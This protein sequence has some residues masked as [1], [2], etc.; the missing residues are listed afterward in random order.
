MPQVGAGEELAHGISQGRQNGPMAEH[1]AKIHLKGVTL[2][3]PSAEIDGRTV[4][5]T[6]QWLKTATVRD[7]ELVQGETIANPESFVAQLKKTRL[8]VDLFTFAQ[9]LPDTTPRYRYYTEWENAAALPITTFSEWWKERTEYSIRKGVNR[10]KKLGLVVK[11]AEFSDELVEGIRR[12][13]SENPVRQG[14]AFWHHGKGFQ[15]LKDE[16]AT[17]LDRSVFIGAY[18]RDEL[19][20]SM[21]ITYVGSTA[22]IMQI[23]STSKH[24]DKRPNNALIA[25][26]VEVCELEGKSHLIYGDF[27]YYDPNSMLTEFKRR[28]GFEPVPAPRYYIPLTFK[29]KVALQLGLH[30]GLAARIPKAVYGKLL[31]IRSAWYAQRLKATE[32][33]L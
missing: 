12:I 18:Y 24:F 14:K 15:V 21:K 23:F 11:V 8:N 33:T 27:V 6:G 4:V 31:K 32:R 10:A 29:G 2:Y 16:L 26:A 20:G 9:R 30:R 3:V 19:I 1:Y 7:E 17:Y 25:K 5:T 13:Y 28:S 22:S